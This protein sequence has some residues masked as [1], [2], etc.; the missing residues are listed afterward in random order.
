MMLGLTKNVQV[1]AAFPDDVPVMQEI[2]AANGLGGYELPFGDTWGAVAV[3]DNTTVAFCVGR[4]I[5]DGILIEDL[6]AI[7]GNDGLRGLASLAEW[8]EEAAVVA[9]RQTGR[10]V[11]VGGAVLLGNE[12]HEAALRKRGYTDYAKILYKEITP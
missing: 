8:V 6:W 5:R 11:N 2:A 12:R 7:P 3:I 9:A 4:D 10:T 1:R